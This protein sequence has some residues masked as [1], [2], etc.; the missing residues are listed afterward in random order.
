MV[1]FLLQLDWK[2]NAQFAGI[3]IAHYRNQYAEQGIDLKIL[4]W[5]AYLNQVDVLKQEGNYIVS[6]EDNLLIRGRASGQPVRAIATMMQY[7]G[8]GW[9]ALKGYRYKAGQIRMV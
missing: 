7:S 3:L 6:T 4:P 8:L 2:P 1:P 5:Q 9:I